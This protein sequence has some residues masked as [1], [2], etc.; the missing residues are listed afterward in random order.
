MRRWKTSRATVK[1]TMEEAAAGQVPMRREATCERRARSPEKAELMAQ[2]RRLTPFF[3]MADYEMVRAWWAGSNHWSL[4][5]NSMLWHK[6]E[7]QLVY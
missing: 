5:V 3:F 2:E 1:S 7:S 6:N 4:G